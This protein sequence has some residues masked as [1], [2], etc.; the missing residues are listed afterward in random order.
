MIE[1]FK[2]VSF[3][4]VISGESDTKKINSKQRQQD[5]EY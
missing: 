3:K 4:A 2:F 1:H 5:L